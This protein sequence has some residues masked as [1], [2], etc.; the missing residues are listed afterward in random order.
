MP[1]TRGR[2]AAILVVSILFAPTLLPAPSDAQDDQT[3]ST[4]NESNL[5]PITAMNFTMSDLPADRGSIGQ[6]ASLDWVQQEN[7]G[8]FLIVKYLDA[9]SGIWDL[10]VANVDGSN[11]TTVARPDNVSSVADATIATISPD[12]RSIF[13]LWENSIY[14]YDMTTKSYSK[15]L[16][17]D[18]LVYFDILPNGN[19]LYAVEDSE[20]LISLYLT[21][22][23]GQEAEKLAVSGDVLDM[24]VFDVSPDGTK[25][26]YRKT[27][28]AVYGNI[29]NGIF[30]YDLD[31]QL[32]REIPIEGLNSCVEPIKWSPNGQFIVYHDVGCTHAECPCGSIALTDMDGNTEQLVA[33]TNLL[34]PNFAISPDGQKIVFSSTPYPV[35]YGIHYGDSHT[36][37]ANLARPIP[38]SHGLAVVL[39]GAGLGIV[40]MLRFW[41][42]F[43]EVKSNVEIC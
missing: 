4:A 31:S 2:L 1:V 11:L 37:T 20:R 29:N 28:H 15:I 39:V 32:E 6:V 5:P 3:L 16:E 17:I 30:V 43:S 38:E 34:P 14:R 18:G 27:L 21:D 13:T 35:R 22:E 8:E 41:G 10:G 24:S 23:S 7:G 33:T 12:K 19:L 26:A 9:R 25:V 42:S 36:Y 40:M